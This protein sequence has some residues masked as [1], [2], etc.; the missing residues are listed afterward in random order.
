MCLMMSVHGV[1][2]L[3]ICSQIQNCLNFISKGGQ[4]FSN[5]NEIDD[6]SESSK[7]GEG[8]YGLIGNFPQ[9]LMFFIMMPPLR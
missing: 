8:A 7:E 5:N 1:L 9:I 4:H 2:P 3:P 6:N